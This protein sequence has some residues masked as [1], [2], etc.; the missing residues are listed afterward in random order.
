MRAA[1]SSR[2]G[3]QNA[4]SLIK[5]G[6]PARSALVGRDQTRRGKEK[7]PVSPG[8]DG[9]KTESPIRGGSMWPKLGSN[10]HATKSCGVRVTVCSLSFA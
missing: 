5:W 2:H 7:L 3:R 6:G 10:V 1:T 9:E 8:G 4:Q